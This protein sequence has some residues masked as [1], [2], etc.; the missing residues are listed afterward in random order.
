MTESG[1]VQAVFFSSLF[2]LFGVFAWMPISR[3]PRAFF[4]VRVETGYFEG[5]GKRVLF[6]YRLVLAAL[7]LLVVAIAAGLRPLVGEPAVVIGAEVVLPLAAF[8]VYLRFASAVRPHASPGG[9][10][11]FA[12]SMRVR[13]ARN[14]GWLDAIVAALAVLAFVAPVLFYDQMP[15]RIPIHWDVTGKVDGWV[16]RNVFVILFIPALGAYM[17]FFLSVLRRD[18]AGAKM[19]LPAD[20]TEEYL[21]AKEKYLQ[22]NIDTLDWTRLMIAVTFCS[23]SLLQTF[24][25]VEQLRAMEPMARASVFLGLVA[26]LGGITFFIVRM[27]RINA[28]LQQQTGNDYAQR[29][30][31]ESHWLHGGLTYSNPD[32]PAL[33]VEKLV[34][35]GYT[36]NMAHPGIRNRLL[37][38]IG[39]PLFVIWAVL[40]M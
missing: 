28:R 32:D 5:A 13:G 19:T 3:G 30:G 31:D 39:F 37:L 15:L 22:T 26:L 38:M 24:A 21:V 9:A 18:F 2:V 23:I 35:V 27:I 7:F 25:A 6:R 40:A 11:R 36:L 29:S 20:S 10:T 8:I 12:S 1:I 14:H 16:E 33:V 34:G 4:G 17:Q